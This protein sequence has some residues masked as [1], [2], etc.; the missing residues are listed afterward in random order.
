[1]KDNHWCCKEEGGGE[2]RHLLPHCNFR[3]NQNWKKEMYLS[4]MNGK[5]K[6]DFLKAIT[7]HSQI[8]RS[9]E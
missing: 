4:Y 2:A 5:I 8:L 1:M 9:D 7:H 3:R 6:K